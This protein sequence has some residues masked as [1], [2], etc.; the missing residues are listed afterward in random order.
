MSDTTWLAA[1]HSITDLETARKAC[2]SAFMAD[3]MDGMTDSDLTTA[4]GATVIANAN[5]LLPSVHIADR[6]FIDQCGRGFQI[7]NNLGGTFG[8]TFAVLEASLPTSTSHNRR[9]ISG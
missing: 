1:N 3:A 5:V 9:M 6:C 7:A 2:G 8:S 4:A